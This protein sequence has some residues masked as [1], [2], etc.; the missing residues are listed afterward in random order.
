MRRTPFYTSIQNVQG[1][2]SE[3]PFGQLSPSAT[4]H[5]F[6]IRSVV[7]VDPTP[8]P[9]ARADSSAGYGFS[10]INPP[11]SAGTERKA[12][13]LSQSSAPSTKSDPGHESIDSP[14]KLRRNTEGEITPIQEKDQVS[15]A[16]NYQVRSIREGE[17]MGG[18]RHIL[19]ST[20]NASTRSQATSGEGSEDNLSTAGSAKSGD[21]AGGLVTA[22]FKHV[23]TEGGHAVIIGRDG[24]T[25]QRC[26]D[27]PIHIPGAVQGFGLLVALQE[28]ADGKLLVK[29]VSE[30]SKRIIGYTPKQLFALD[31]F[32]DILSEEQT[33]NLLDHIDFINDEDV[34]P[35]TNGPEVFTLAIRSPTRKSLKMWCAMHTNENNGDLI[36]CEFELE[37]D[38]INPL[39][40][41]GEST[42]EPPEDTLN[43]NPSAEEFA[44]S[45]INASKPLRVLRTARKRK[46]EAAAM[47]VFNIMSQVQ[48]QLANATNL[49]VFL[50]ILVG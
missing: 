18:S 40:P 24:E 20:D 36:I 44:E 30:N 19:A 8:T 23:V 10:G 7:S 39:V 16:P 14:S 22:R 34:D 3:S 37:E 35:A 6:P 9:L 12:D 43:T 5:V 17:R 25:L 26:E 38:T 29:V 42:P 50:K 1:A 21:D 28:T 11:S 31:N 2:G 41:P 27:E 46:G 15:A 47:E 49:D 45:T 48:E 4:D 13:A 33:E 32:C